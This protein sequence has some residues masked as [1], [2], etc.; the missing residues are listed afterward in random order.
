MKY[1]LL[2]RGV[3]SFAVQVLSVILNLTAMALLARSLGPHGYGAFTFTL[4]VT[5][6]LLIPASAGLAPLTVRLTAIYH[7]A[8]DWPKI[9]GLW[10]RVTQWAL[11]YGLAAAVVLIAATWF[12]WF[13]QIDTVEPKTLYVATS[14]IFLMAPLYTFAGALR[15]IEKTLTS[16]LPEHFIRP[17]VFLVL[18]VLSVILV[19]STFVSP[20]AAMALNA[21]AAGVGLVASVIWIRSFEPTQQLPV[22]PVYESRSWIAIAVPLSVSGGLLVIHGQTDTLMLG[23]LNGSASVGVYKSASQAAN[24]V[25]FSLLV[26]NTV[27]APLV[28]QYHTDKRR[29]ELQRLVVLTT[30]T[31]FLGALLLFLT[32]VGFGQ[33]I[34]GMVFGGAYTAAY[35][36]LLILSVGHLCNVFAGPVAMI[37]NMTGHHATALYSLGVAALLNISM[38][39]LLIPLYGLFGAAVAT[40]VSLVTWNALLVYWTFRKVSIDSTVIGLSLRGR[41]T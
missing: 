34:L 16:Q 31:A 4:A 15:G 30:R 2:R 24:L 26:A 39:A 25:S 32:Y 21:A 20:V 22:A 12:G 7:G 17:G 23:W 14:F 36:P 38:N 8:D 37:L 13:D 9:R 27:M 41:K 29:E 40:T 33:R 18:L 28:A 1:E 11:S 6:V 35:A 3:G 10:R 5:N 19:G